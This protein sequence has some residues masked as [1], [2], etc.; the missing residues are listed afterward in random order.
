MGDSTEEQASDSAENYSGNQSPPP[1]LP[2]PPDGANGSGAES[3]LSTKTY[4]FSF[5]GNGYEFFKI[6][7]VNLALTILTL[8][9]YSAWAKVRTNRY[10]Y[11]HFQLDGEGFEYH[12][13]PLEILKGRLIAV[14][15][16]LGYYFLGS[17]SLA[18]GAL[19][20][21]ALLLLYPVIAVLSLRFHR[22]V[23]SYRNLHFRFHGRYRDAYKTFVLWP[24]LGV[25]S[26]GILY[27][28]VLIKLDRF[29]IGNTA[30]GT[31]RFEFS[32]KY[33]HYAKLFLIGI[34]AYLVY[35]VA[36]LVLVPT[37]ADVAY[38]RARFS[39]LLVFPFYAVMLYLYARFM[40]LRFSLITLREHG[41]D[42]RFTARGIAWVVLT[43]L[44]L[45]VVTL[46]LFLPFA[47]VRW[48]RYRANCLSLV[49]QGTLDD[50]MAAEQ[51]KAS[52]LS[53]E[54]G[55]AFDFDLGIGV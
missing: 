52:A 50:F 49:T 9:I 39:A 37:G 42:S 51:D 4:D 34:V 45:I 23:S 27:P 28:L 10:F 18:A 26:F 14:G 32:G 48:T 40:N 5:T 7:I 36:T 24:L 44:A 2:T 3:S 16:L 53:Q 25:L 41:F 43:N 6:W 13:K 31:E 17:L 19:A 20:G 55:E 22:R 8:G 11:S 21:I 46:G 47:K 15:L 29:I 30:Y 54:V 12:A 35:L 1:T 38:L 33:G